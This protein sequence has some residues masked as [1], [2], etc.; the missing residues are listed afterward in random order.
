AVLAVADGI[1]EPRTLGWGKGAQVEEAAPRIHHTL[2][3]ANRAVVLEQLRTCGDLLRRKRGRR[4][5]I[6]RH[7]V[8]R[9]YTDSQSDGAAQI[10]RLKSGREHC[11][12]PFGKSNAAGAPGTG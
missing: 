10:T 11:W 3:M 5:V 8:R 12:N 9:G 4:V 1:H 2:A 6:V 7:G